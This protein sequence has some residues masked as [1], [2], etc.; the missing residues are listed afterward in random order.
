MSTTVDAKVDAIKDYFEPLLKEAD[1][2]LTLEFEQ[3]EDRLYVNAVGPDADLLLDQRNDV[4]RELSFLATQFLKLHLGTD[5]PD[6]R[7]DVDGTQREREEEL[8]DLAGDVR[9]S[10]EKEG[11]EEVIGPFNPYERRL[12]HLALQDD[13]IKTESL[14]D[15]HHKK[16][17]VRWVG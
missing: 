11:G 5:T 6:V 2:D 4:A 1:L 3:E 14:G 7:F 8:N 17:R 16:I 15:G 9:E 12:I 13:R 10:L